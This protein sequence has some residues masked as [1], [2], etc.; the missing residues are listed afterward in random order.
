MIKTKVIGRTANDFEYQVR[1]ELEME[2]T[3]WRRRAAAEKQAVFGER[4]RT[5]AMT[6]LEGH[7]LSTILSS[8]IQP[9]WLPNS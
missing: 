4:G 5:P 9:P 2:G 7:A 6:M 8:C 3:S 1:T